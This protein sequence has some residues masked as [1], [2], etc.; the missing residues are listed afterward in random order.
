VKKARKIPTVIVVT[1]LPGSGK[2]TLLKKLEAEDKISGFCDDYQNNP[3]TKYK[4]P[5]LSP[6]YERLVKGLR[7]GETWA[8]SEIRY[9]DKR[10]RAIFVKAIRQSVAGVKFRYVFFENRPDIC[11]SNVIIRAGGLQAHQKSLIYY[12]TDLYEIPKNTR[13]LPIHR[14]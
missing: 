10:E 1:G 8:V 12:Y 4:D 9:C 2:T 5:K 7:N 14:L 13:P 11:E 3:V 6:Q